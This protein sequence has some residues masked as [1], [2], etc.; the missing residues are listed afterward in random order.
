ME[1][2]DDQDRDFCPDWY[3]PTGETVCS[4]LAHRQI[5]IEKFVSQMGQTIEWYDDF[6][7][8]K[9]RVDES[10]AEKLAEVLGSTPQFWLRREQ[11]FRAE[12]LRL[13]GSED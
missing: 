5:P 3:S 11:H 12:K 7:E 10:L 13:T 4:V 2:E 8:G 9:V 1:Q 6:L